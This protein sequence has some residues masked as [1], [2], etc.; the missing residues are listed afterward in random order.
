MRGRA[1]RR[2]GPLAWLGT[3]SGAG[4]LAIVAGSAL[5]GAIITVVERQDPG[6]VLGVLLVLGTI[7]AG[8]GVKTRSA[9][10]IIPAPVFCYVPTAVIAGA[11]NDRSED[12]SKIGLI[13]HGGKWISS[14]FTAMSL[15]TILAILIT[16]VRLFLDYRIRSTRRPR[17]GASAKSRRP[18][19]RDRYG[20]EPDDDLG[21]TRP[22]GTGPAPATGPTAP[23][24]G[25]ADGRGGNGSGAWRQQGAGGYPPPPGSGGYPQPGSG[26]GGYPQPGSGSGGYPQ[27]QGPGGYPPPSGSGQYPQPQPQG[28]GQYPQPPRGSGPHR[29]PDNGGYPGHPATE[30]GYPPQ[31]G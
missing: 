15:A 25:P 19:P 11:I 24:S 8:L 28:S 9:R 13:V 20:A 7:A 27:P 1:P 29:G 12:S 18:A 30:G 23:V 16:G 21:L 17:Q 3:L 14:G 5:L 26:S 22:I 4:G 10:L 2:Q 6:V 31:R